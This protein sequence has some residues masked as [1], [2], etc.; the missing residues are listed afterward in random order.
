MPAGASV[1]KT[2]QCPQ[3][4]QPMTALPL[5]GHYGNTVHTDLC[6]PCRLVWLDELEA[7]NLSGLGWVS[8]LRRLQQ[9]RGDAPPS[10]VAA[11]DCPRCG[12]TLKPVHNLTV[13][14]RFGEL[15]C[16]RCRGGLAGFAALLARRGLVRAMTRRDLDALKTENREPACLNCGAGLEREACA[17]GLLDRDARCG[18]CTSPLLV[19][20]MPRFFTA[21]LSRH[22]EPVSA[23]RLAWPCRACGATVEPTQGAACVDCGHPVVVPALIDLSPLLDRAEPLLRGTAARGARPHG[24]RLREQ[25][26]D[27]RTTGLYRLLLRL[28]DFVLNRS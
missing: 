26:G 8:L 15:E 1:H 22:A 16:P 13:M 3:C 12:A 5:E 21:L 11:C 24:S 27:Y 17:R 4:R 28:K 23:E 14:G 6:A 18:Y 2:L 25:R 10:A 19:M 9:A 20:D 7:V